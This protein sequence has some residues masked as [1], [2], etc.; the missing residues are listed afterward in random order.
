MESLVAD[1]KKLKQMN[2]FGLWHRHFWSRVR[3]LSLL[4]LCCWLIVSCNASRPP[5][6]TA[7]PATGGGGESSKQQ[8]RRE[9][10]GSGTRR[11]KRRDEHLLDGDDD[12]DD[13]EGDGADLYL[14]GGRRP[15]GSLPTV[16][17]WRKEMV[18]KTHGTAT[19]TR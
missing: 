9:K 15:P 19:P 1:M 12:D 10:N 5:A 14:D 3:F 13:D 11:S 18:R 17:A 7:T 16:E 8:R 6:Q 4:G 2:W